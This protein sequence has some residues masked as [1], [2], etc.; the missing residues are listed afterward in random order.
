MWAFQGNF[1]CV[2]LW[3][4]G[5][6]KFNWNKELFENSP[7]Y[8][9]IRPSL[10]KALY[11]SARW[12]YKFI[13]QL[14]Y[15]HVKIFPNPHEYFAISVSYSFASFHKS[16]WIWWQ[17]WS[18]WFVKICTWTQVSIKMNL[19]VCLAF[20]YRHVWHNIHLRWCILAELPVIEMKL[21]EENGS[22]HLNPSSHE[23]EGINVYF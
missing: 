23:G 11:M 5:W 1:T 16:I 6:V 21:N 15:I 7:P 3:H 8:M 13:F 9:I 14:T 19:D 20:M 17:I 2:Q 4:R 22:N 10:K 18:C 12:T